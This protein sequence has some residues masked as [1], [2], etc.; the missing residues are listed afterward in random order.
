[1][2]YTK[3]SIGSAYEI[4][5][6]NERVVESSI[7]KMQES[8]DGFLKKR[9]WEKCDDIITTLGEMGEYMLG[10]SLAKRLTA[11]KMT[12]LADYGEEKEPTDSDLIEEALTESVW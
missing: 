5:L 6:Q 8:F 4:D 9:N 11:R 10:I 1:M 12:L 7:Q 2:T 3:D